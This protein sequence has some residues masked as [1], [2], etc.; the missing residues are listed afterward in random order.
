MGGTTGR[1]SAKAGEELPL[2]TGSNR[3]SAKSLSIRNPAK[4]LYS[5]GE[6]PLVGAEPSN[7]YSGRWL[8]PLLVTCSTSSRRCGGT[9]GSA[10]PGCR[11]WPLSNAALVKICWRLPHSRSAP[12]RRELDI[13]RHLAHLS[14]GA[15]ARR[16]SRQGR[17]PGTGSR[18]CSG[19]RAVAPW[20]VPIGRCAFRHALGGSSALSRK[21][22]R[23]TG[24]L[25]TRD[26]NYDSNHVMPYFRDAAA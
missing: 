19:R 11:R 18:A 4:C 14:K 13:P 16:P 25:P 7:A 24:S 6:N 26:M 21:S 23:C 20:R 15:S 17:Q 1:Q 2:C 9:R 12:T 5:V 22:T 10:R 8:I 3:G